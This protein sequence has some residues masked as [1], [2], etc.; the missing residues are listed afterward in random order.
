LTEE[1]E[2]YQQLERRKFCGRLINSLRRREHFEG[3]ADKQLD[4]QGAQD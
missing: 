1:T 4:R 2:T 3:E